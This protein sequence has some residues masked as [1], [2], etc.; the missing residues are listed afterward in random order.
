MVVE[1]LLAGGKN[2]DRG[3]LELLDVQG[4]VHPDCPAEQVEPFFVVLVRDSH[5][6]EVEGEVSFE[7]PVV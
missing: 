5:R 3:L 2:V 4:V 1:G 7:R 6:E